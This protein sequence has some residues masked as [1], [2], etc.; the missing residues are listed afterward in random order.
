MS[1]L[2][3]G[4]ECQ[5]TAKVLSAFADPR[6]GAI[7]PPFITLAMGIAIFKG[8]SGVAVVRLKSG[9]W[10]APCAIKVASPQSAIQP[11]Q[12]TVLLFMTESAI[13]S[14]V[15]QGTFI[16]GQTHRFAPGPLYGTALNV[17]PAIDVYAFV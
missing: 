12:D 9:E 16:F 10:S 7:T 14:L 1:G 8:D 11:A 13:F 17:D 5:L 15:G 6:Q 3:A 2:T 4:E